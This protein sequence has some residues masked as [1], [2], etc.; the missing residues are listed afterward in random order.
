MDLNRMLQQFWEYE[1]IF[2]PPPFTPSEMKVIE[3]FD[4]TTQRDATGRFIV[5]LPFDDSKPALGESLSS[6]TKRL[7]SMERRFASNP[8][9]H[10]EYVNFMR[11]YLEL[12]HMELVPAD[13]LE[14]QTSEHYYLPHHAVIK[15]DSST[16][17]LR[18][19]FDGSCGTPTGVSLNDQLFRSY[20]VAFSVDIAKMYRQV[21]VSEDD[22][23]FQRVVWRENTDLPIQHYRLSTVTYGTKTAPYLAIR[24]MRESA[25]DYTSTHPAAVE[26]TVHD[27]Y[28]DD[29]LSGA[30]NEEEA[31]CIKQE[32]SDILSK[33]GFELRKWA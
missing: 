27:F 16:T 18:V 1:E 24:A 22:R 32:T 25:K 7:M 14:K 12:N 33:S 3:H 5:K 19:V 2:K 17:K 20:K 30:N 11:E 8:E 4:S 6:A 28:V 9:F 29:L 23:D 10:Q 15:A 13:Q 21:L 31:A 26:R